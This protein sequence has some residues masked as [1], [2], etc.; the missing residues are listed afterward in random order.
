MRAR[1]R[2]EFERCQELLPFGQSD[3]F[4]HVRV[5]Y[6]GILL[7][8]ETMKEVRLSK[9]PFQ[10]YGGVNLFGKRRLTTPPWVSS[11]A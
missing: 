2:A 10:V 8:K 11:A 7:E 4:V 3:H 1:I 6:T 5:D 9:A